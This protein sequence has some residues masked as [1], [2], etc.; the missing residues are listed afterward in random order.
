M[1]LSGRLNRSV[2]CRFVLI[3]SFRMNV[4]KCDPLYR[5]P[6]I[7]EVAQ[8][9]KTKPAC[10]FKDL[11]GM[12][13]W[14]HQQYQRLPVVSEFVDYDP[15]SSFS[16]MKSDVDSRKR[17]KVSARN[18]FSLFDRQTNLYFRAVH[19][20]DHINSLSDFSLPGEIR[21]FRSIANRCGDEEGRLFLFCEIVAQACFSVIEGYFGEQKYITIPPSLPDRTSLALL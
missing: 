9:Y 11:G 15:Y 6:T 16:E 3:F 12:S 10:L 4:L 17:M 2:F 19:D 13:S 21:A 8:L 20:N 5:H 18:N 14:I 7:R 1:I